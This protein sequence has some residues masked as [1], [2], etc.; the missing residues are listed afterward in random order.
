MGDPNQE[1]S[2]GDFKVFSPF[3]NP[4][5][6]P[7]TEQQKLYQGAMHA[8]FRSW[9]QDNLLGFK[10]E[11]HK[12]YNYRYAKYWVTTRNTSL[13]NLKALQATINIQNLPMKVNFPGDTE[14]PGAG[15]TYITNPNGTRNRTYLS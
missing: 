7:L 9:L 8:A 4:G 15:D 10:Q 3:R 11:V 13:E 5:D 14:N 1:A 6:P 2:L 12:Y